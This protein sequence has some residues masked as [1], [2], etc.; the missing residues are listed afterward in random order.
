MNLTDPAYKQWLTE[1]KGKI[2]S[3]Q[4]KAVISVN[5]ALI[6][7][8]WELG[9]MISGKQAAWGSKLLETLSRDLQDEFREMKVFSV[10]NLKTCNN[11]GNGIKST[12]KDKNNLWSKRNGLW[13]YTAT[14]I[15]QDFDTQ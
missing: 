12:K 7:F 4:L 14:I 10:S 3:V 6:Q 2:R 9:K 5:S 8:Y 15:L 1:L 11:D 13:S